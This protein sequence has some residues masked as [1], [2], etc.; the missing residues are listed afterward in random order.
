MSDPA[1]ATLSDRHAGNVV[2]AD[3]D[4]LHAQL[5]LTNREIEVLR[6]LTSGRS[7]QEIADELCITLNTAERHVA[8]IYRKLHVRSRTHAAAYALQHGLI[9]PPQ[10]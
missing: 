4:R 7:N 6:L 2:E 10:P 8:N 9:P 5:Q 1:V 3:R